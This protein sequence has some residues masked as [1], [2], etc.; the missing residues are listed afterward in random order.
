MRALL[1]LALICCGLF[2]Q[3]QDGF[4]SSL[5]RQPGWLNP[6][7]IGNISGD[8]RGQTLYRREWPGLAAPYITSMLQA[9]AQPWRSR[10]EKHYFG[11]GLTVLHDQ[12]GNRALNHLEVHGSAAINLASSDYNQWTFGL[13]VGYIRRTLKSDELRWDN[14]YNGV[15][16]DPSLPTGE[17]LIGATRGHADAA[18]GMRWTHTK[19]L[20]YTVGY[21]AHHFLQ[22]RSLLVHTQD[23]YRMRHT[24]TVETQVKH[25]AFVADYYVLFM[26]QSGAQW[27]QG[28]ALFTYGFGENSR[29]T[30]ARAKS[31]VMGGLS[32]RWGDALTPCLGVCWKRWGEML[33]AYDLTLSSWRRAVG[34]R[35]GWEVH[36]RYDGFFSTQ[37]RRLK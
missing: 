32:Y 21:A 6:A 20:N 16:Y 35:G 30:T 17:A 8:F 1:T 27:L 36:L 25:Q 5:N 12:L 14:Q 34:Y 24:L 31:A 9:E 22:D 11:T 18:F 10:Y 28:G 7:A 15:G 29:Y 33:L 19:K 13:Q 23:D 3:A 37:R 4:A 26:R 2:A